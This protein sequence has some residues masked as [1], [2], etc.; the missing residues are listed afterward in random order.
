MQKS[1][2]LGITG[3]LLVT[4]TLGFVAGRMT[5]DPEENTDSV[6]AQGEQDTYQSRSSRRDSN[7]SASSSHSR[8]SARSTKDIKATMKHLI[9]EMERSPMVNM[10]FDSIFSIWEIARDF[11]EDEVRE[12]LTYIDSMKNMQVK[13]TLEMMLMNRWGKING[14]AAM[15]HAMEAGTSQTRMMQMMGTLMSWTKEDPNAAFTWFEKNKG[16]AGSGIYANAYESMIYQALAKHDLKRALTQLEGIE[17]T[18]KKQTALSSIA[19]GVANDPEKLQSFIQYLDEKEP[20]SKKT[21]MSSVIS[22]LAMTSSEAAK[23]YIKTIDDP[24]E[25]SELVTTIVQSLS[26]TDPEEAIKWGMENASDEAAQKKVVEKALNNWISQ[27]FKTAA[28]WYDKQPEHLK[29]DD[30]IKKSALS[31]AAAGQYKDAFAWIERGGDAEAMKKTKQSTYSMWAQMSP[32]K[33]KAWLE[34]DGQKT[35]QGIDTNALLHGTDTGPI[36]VIPAHE[37]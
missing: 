13:M 14:E 32:A 33:A 17:N 20:D 21:I 2:L 7:A 8:K 23:N 30:I 28:A 4:A 1:Q 19:Q 35:M 31:L 15:E 26:Y 5:G 24:E 3:A 10:D 37:E 22:Q 6:K 29:S 12:S 18:Q 34:G 25:K 16:K 11:S 36:P 9:A 27:D